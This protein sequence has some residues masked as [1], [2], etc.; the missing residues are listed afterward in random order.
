M[1]YR[2]NPYKISMVQQCG[3]SVGVLPLG[4]LS[5]LAKTRER[6]YLKY[7]ICNRAPAIILF[8]LKAKVSGNVWGRQG[9]YIWCVANDNS[10]LIIAVVLIAGRC[11]FSIGLHH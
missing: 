11:K 8:I 10:R 2:T 9:A 5:S 3:R 6:D 1:A 4:V 7:I